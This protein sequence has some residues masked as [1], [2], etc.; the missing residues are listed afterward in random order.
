MGNLEKGRDKWRGSPVHVDKIKFIPPTWFVDIW[1]L[2]Q[3]I[4]LIGHIT[5]VQDDNIFAKI[6]ANCYC[7]QIYINTYP[8][9]ISSISIPFT[10]Y[11]NNI[12]NLHLLLKDEKK[13]TNLYIQFEQI[14]ILLLENCPDKIEFTFATSRSIPSF[15]YIN[16]N[17]RKIGSF[18]NN[19]LG[20]FYGEL[21]SFRFGVRGV[22]AYGGPR[23]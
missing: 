3:T 18:R 1:H 9:S 13:I 10:W 7:P 12:V 15:D 6:I 14:R 8:L 22:Y 4:F 21:A 2:P 11:V 17:Q 20:W 16:M 23:S 5:Y 19:L